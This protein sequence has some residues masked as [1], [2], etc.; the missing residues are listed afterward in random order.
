MAPTVFAAF[1]A[2]VRSGRTE[3]NNSSYMDK[4]PEPERRI[5]GSVTRRV[6]GT[7]GGGTDRGST[8]DGSTDAYRHARAYTR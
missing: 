3:R 6:I 7:R 8:D 1:T 2:W 5:A 4:R